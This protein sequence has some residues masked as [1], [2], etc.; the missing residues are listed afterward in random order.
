MLLSKDNLL[1]LKSFSPSF[2][3]T[4][5]TSILF[6]IGS[7]FAALKTTLNIIIINEI[8]LKMLFTLVILI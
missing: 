6:G 4:L 5:S 1:S 8:S 3:F 2:A 7:I